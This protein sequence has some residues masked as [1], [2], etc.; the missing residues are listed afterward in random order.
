M[1]EN[2]EEKKKKEKEEENKKTKKER[3]TLSPLQPKSLLV[4]HITLT[5][6]ASDSNPTLS[7]ARTDTNPGA[8]GISVL[9]KVQ[10]RSLFTG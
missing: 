3:T 4:L 6:T 8:S 5:L 1:N 7:S 2:E 9:R 10:W